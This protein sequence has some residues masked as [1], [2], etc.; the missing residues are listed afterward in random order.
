M[1][2]AKEDAPCGELYLSAQQLIE[3]NSSLRE[4]L[5]LFLGFWTTSSLLTC[6]YV[7]RAVNRPVEKFS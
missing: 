7:N 2:L 3:A 6:S 1:D 4:I 5:D